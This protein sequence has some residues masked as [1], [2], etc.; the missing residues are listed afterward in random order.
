MT[1]WRCLGRTAVR[2]LRGVGRNSE[3]LGGAAA[4]RR[5][6]PESAF[7]EKRTRCVA[8]LVRTLWLHTATATPHAALAAPRRMPDG[9]PPSLEPPSFSLLNRLPPFTYLAHLA[10]QPPPTPWVWPTLR[11]LGPVLVSS[12]ALLQGGVV[13]PGA[14]GE[15]GPSE[16]SWLCLV[17]PRLFRSNSWAGPV[18][19]SRI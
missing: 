5:R 17:S 4:A 2:A 10:T 15:L 8:C 6:T 16:S 1:R 18:V 9:R 13:D 3:L 12:Q 7:P 14:V 11:A 19:S